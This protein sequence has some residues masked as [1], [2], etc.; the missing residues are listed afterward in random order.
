MSQLLF[1]IYCVKSD[2]NVTSVVKKPIKE[3]ISFYKPIKIELSV[4]RRT[5]NA[6]KQLNQTFI[7]DSFLI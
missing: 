6:F 7:L 2:E 5:E 1:T 3:K 4:A